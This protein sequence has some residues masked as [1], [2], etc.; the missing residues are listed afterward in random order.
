MKV[1][2][3]NLFFRS[4]SMK[5]SEFIYRLR[6]SKGRFLNNK[7]YT[8]EVNK[9]YISEIIKKEH[10]CLEFYFIIS[11]VKEDVGVVRIYQINNDQK[12]FT[13]GSWIMLDGISP[14]YALISSIMVYAFA[15]DFLRLE[16]SLF[17]VRNENKK[18]ISFHEKTGAKFLKK[19]EQDMFFCFTKMN[20]QILRKK[21]EKYIGSIN[22]KE[23]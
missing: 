19:D 23:I 7:G 13:W 21:Y 16:K 2:S 1:S 4:V 14:L 6:S 18:V 5:D 17:D 22:F 20:Y 15:F 12:T 3:K 8:K 10:E 11:D 9:N